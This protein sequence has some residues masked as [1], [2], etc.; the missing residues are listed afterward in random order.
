MIIGNKKNVRLFDN[1][2]NLK[3]LLLPTISLANSFAFIDSNKY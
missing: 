3:I 2:K 1:S